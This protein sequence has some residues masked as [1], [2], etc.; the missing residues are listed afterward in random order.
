LQ[1]PSSEQ[2]NLQPATWNLELTTEDRW[3][4][5]R[6]ATVTAGV[7]EAF[8]KYHYADAAKMLYDFAWDEFCSF[9]VEIAKARLA[10]EKS[11][12][13][14]QR[15]LAHA[16][17]TLCRLLHPVMPFITEEIWQLL[18]KVAPHRGITLDKT[19]PQSA[20]PN[21]QSAPSPWLIKATWPEADLRWQDGEIESRFTIFQ[22]ALGAVREIR[23]RQNIATREPLEFCI[24]CDAATAALLEPMKPYFRSMTNATATGFGP[25]VPIPPT[26]AKSALPGL[27]LFVDL[28]G[29]IDVEAELAKNEQQEQK[30]LGLIK[31]KEGK[32]KNESF[33]SRAPANVVQAER[34]SLAQLQEQL[35]S[36]RAALAALRK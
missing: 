23:S 22:Q 6:L 30:L 24:K 29:L 13:T 5:S 20:I 31:A 33:V 26:H 17:D 25:E 19:N 35:A 7:T 36:V 8:E 34:D 16:L 21:P 11:R 10:D 18:N 15:V 27:E 12:P 28:A 14:A 4:L 32:L 1:V 3:L 9:Y 2:D